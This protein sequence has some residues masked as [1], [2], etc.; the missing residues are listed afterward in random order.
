[1]LALGQTLCSSGLE[2]DAYCA[3]FYRTAGLSPKSSLGIEFGYWLH[4]IFLCYCVDGLDGTRLASME[5]AEK[6]KKDKKDKKAKKQAL[7][8]QRYHGNPTVI[9]LDTTV[10]PLDIF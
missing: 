9:P 5:H 7:R 4:C 8:V 10:T 6:D 2:P 1:M 3:E